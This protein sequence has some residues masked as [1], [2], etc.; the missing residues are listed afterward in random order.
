MFGGTTQERRAVELE[1]VSR[2]KELFS[3]PDW[4]KLFTH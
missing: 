2:R 3:N 1:L 4:Y